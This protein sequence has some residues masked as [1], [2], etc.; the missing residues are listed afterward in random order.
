MVGSEQFETELREASLLCRMV[1]GSL[2][3]HGPDEVRSREDRC[4]WRGNLARGMLNVQE[5]LACIPAFCRV[6]I[7]HDS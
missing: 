1:V 2:P 3:R 4:Y 6:G 7:P 5:W